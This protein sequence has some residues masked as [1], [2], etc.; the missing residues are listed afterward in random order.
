MSEGI[1][2]EKKPVEK[3]DQL[4]RTLLTPISFITAISCSFDMFLANLFFAYPSQF[5]DFFKTLQG[6]TPRTYL[7][8]IINYSAWDFFFL[9]CSITIFCFVFYKKKKGEISGR[10]ASLFFL[11]LDL[12]FVL[13]PR[14]LWIGEMSA[15]TYFFLALLITSILT[16][17]I[18]IK[19]GGRTRNMILLVVILS[20]IT[21]LLTYG[22]KFQ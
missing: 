5:E 3:F 12:L 11:F 10:I 6:I 8:A 14:M 9:F 13:Y 20:I 7:D 18:G 19:M 4:Y 16:A 15:T 1:E 21:W 2:R 22:F 17:Y